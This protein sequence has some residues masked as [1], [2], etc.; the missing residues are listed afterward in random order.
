M[1]ETKDL[2][3]VFIKKNGPEALFW[4]ILGRK[5][6]GVGPHVSFLNYGVYV[7]G[8]KWANIFFFLVMFRILNSTVKYIRGPQN[9]F[10]Q[11][12]FVAH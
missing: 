9:I 8:A 11:V 1:L 5:N 2:I 7:T 3:K 4:P 6:Y 12:T 10:G